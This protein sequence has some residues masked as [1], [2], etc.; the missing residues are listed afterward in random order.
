MKSSVNTLRLQRGPDRTVCGY[1]LLG[2]KRY[3][4]SPFPR[5]TGEDDN[6][7]ECGEESPRYGAAGG[8]ANNYFRTNL[9]SSPS[10]KRYK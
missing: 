6:G 7:G 10:Y 9:R 1:V 2:T 4:P 8:T 5:D 3:K